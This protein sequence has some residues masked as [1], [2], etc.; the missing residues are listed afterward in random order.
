MNYLMSRL[1]RGLTLGILGIVALI[2]GW[3]LAVVP[4]D[5]AQ[6]VGVIMIFAGI[7]LAF[8]GFSYAAST[9]DEI[10][11]EPEHAINNPQTEHEEE[12]QRRADLAPEELEHLHG[13]NKIGG[14]GR[15]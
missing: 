14:F 12:V 10:W 7:G 3:M 5:V 6:A 2:S 11:A 15:H 8:Y 13:F 9:S 4:W 1:V